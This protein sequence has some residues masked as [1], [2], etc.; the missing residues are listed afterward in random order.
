MKFEKRYREILESLRAAGSAEGAALKDIQVGDTYLRLVKKGKSF[1]VRRG[2]GPT[3]N[4]AK[5]K[6]VFKG[7]E[8]A[9][10]KKINSLH[11]KLVNSL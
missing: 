10:M 4:Q 3:A 1:V 7:S 11:L 6:T 5:M 2:K 8:E 9:A